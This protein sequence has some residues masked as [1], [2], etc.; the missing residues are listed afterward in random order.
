MSIFLHLTE[1]ISENGRLPE[2][3]VGGDEQPEYTSLEHLRNIERKKQKRVQ[4]IPILIKELIDWVSNHDGNTPN[5]LSEDLEEVKL[6]LLLKAVKNGDI[7]H[8][9]SFKKIAEE[10]G[11]PNLLDRVSASIDLS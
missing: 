11:Y 5:L 2:L 4:L 3:N 9:D 8:L 10:A 6:A 1:W 7:K